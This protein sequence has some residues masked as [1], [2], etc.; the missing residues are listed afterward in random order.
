MVGNEEN[1]QPANEQSSS[2]LGQDSNQKN[3]HPRKE[4][5][6][7]DANI[8]QPQPIPLI[9]PTINGFK[10]VARYDTCPPYLVEYKKINGVQ[11]YHS[12]F[13]TLLYVLY[14][15]VNGKYYSIESQGDPSA[16]LDNDIAVNIKVH[17][18]NAP[19]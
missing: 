7:L 18:D 12:S 8:S 11:V 4:P 2:K 19:V 13:N 17:I 5:E 3:L 15:S 9:R 6:A 1:T 10:L 14:N 16:N